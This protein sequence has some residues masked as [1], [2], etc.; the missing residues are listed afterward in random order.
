MAKGSISSNS[1]NPVSLDREMI[2]PSY[3]GVA[4]LL[5]WIYLLFYA[6]SAGIEAAAPISLMGAPYT[7]S[8]TVMCVVILVIAFGPASF[9]QAIMTNKVKIASSY[10]NRNS[11]YDLRRRNWKRLAAYDRICHHRRFFRHFGATV[12]CGL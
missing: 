3:S 5:C 4:F 11:I 12:D 6:N 8:S 9:S 1:I 2:L 7:L 10:I